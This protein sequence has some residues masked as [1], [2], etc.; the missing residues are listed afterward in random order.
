M[1]KVELAATTFKEGFDC[2]QSVLVTFSDKTA[3]DR[4]TAL[5]LGNPF[6]GGMGRMGDT[7][8][9]VTGALMVIG[10]IHGATEPKNKKAKAKTV[11]LV[12]EFIEKFSELNGSST[13]RE[14]IGHDIRSIGRLSSGRRKEV[15]RKCLKAVQDAVEILEEI[16]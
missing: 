16:L 2:A 14:I 9:A 12:N 6:A 4:D 1:N 7:C 3:L 11:K 10:L 5:R 8:G 13:C 15:H